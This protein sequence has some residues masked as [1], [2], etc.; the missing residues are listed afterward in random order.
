MNRLNTKFGT[1]PAKPGQEIIWSESAS[2]ENY[3]K[4]CYWNFKNIDPEWIENE[5]MQYFNKNDSKLT[6]NYFLSDK[7]FK[8]LKESAYQVTTN[9]QLGDQFG[10]LQNYPY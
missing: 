1:I 8:Y 3:T 5:S 2:S 6:H 7:V 10:E 4:N 9:N